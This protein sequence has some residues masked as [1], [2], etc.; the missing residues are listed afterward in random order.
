MMTWL[1]MQG[2]Q[3]VRGTRV[4]D[5]EFAEDGGKIS[6]RSLVLDQNACDVAVW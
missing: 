4:T 2:V 5:I 3:F 1:D 6:V